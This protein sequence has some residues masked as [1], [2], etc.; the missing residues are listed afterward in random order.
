[1]TD[2]YL[3][4]FEEHVK[5]APLPGAGVD[6]IVLTAG[7]AAQAEGVAESLVGLLREFGRAAEGRVV[8]VAGDCGRALGQGLAGATHPLVLITTAVEPWTR[9]HLDP[10]LESVD[11]C[12]HVLGRRPASVR[13]RL[14]RRLGALWQRLI[15]AVPVADVHSPCRLHRREKLAVIPRQSTSA[16][17]DVEILAKATFLGHLIDEVDVPALREGPLPPSARSDF[18]A[19]FRQPTFVGGS[20]PAEDAQGE[21]ERHEGPGG[22]DGHRGGDVEPAGP[23]QDHPAQG[24]DELR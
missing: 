22:Q 23:L 5:R 9:A 1:M 19:V 24:V 20:G 7:Q 11:K 18:L 6:V 8:D 15:F 10:L 17:L 16:F 21:Q 3:D 12:D 13:A 2:D 14:A 4:P